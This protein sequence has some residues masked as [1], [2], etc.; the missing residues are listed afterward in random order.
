VPG[1]TITAIHDRIVAQLD[2]WIAYFEVD[3][4]FP[5]TDPHDALVDDSGP[6]AVREVTRE[7]M[8]Y[9]SGARLTPPG[10]A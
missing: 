2:D 10:P 1:G 8:E 7:Q 9:G 6:N 3:G 4:S 5:G